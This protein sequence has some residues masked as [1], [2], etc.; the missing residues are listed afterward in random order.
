MISVMDGAFMQ[1]AEAIR[2]SMLMSIAETPC[3]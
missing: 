1:D 3:V 2:L